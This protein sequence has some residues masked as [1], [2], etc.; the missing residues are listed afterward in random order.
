MDKKGKKRIDLE[1]DV[2][3][4]IEIG[5]KINEGGIRKIVMINENG[6]N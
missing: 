5:E 1:E 3:K 6:G 2:K 4:W